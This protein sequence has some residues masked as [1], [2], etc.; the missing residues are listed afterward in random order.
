MD[1]WLVGWQGRTRWNGRTRLGGEGIGI[2]S[3]QG[4]I[5]GRDAVAPAEISLQE[6]P[7]SGPGRF[8]I[9]VAGCSVVDHAM[10]PYFRRRACW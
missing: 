8:E 2:R 3:G 9:G 4:W 7:G 1:G 5:G 6:G 10:F